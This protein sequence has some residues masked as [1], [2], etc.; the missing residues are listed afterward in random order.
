[1]APGKEDI[2]LQPVRFKSRGLYLIKYDLP[3]SVVPAPL[4][5]EENMS[6]RHMGEE[7]DVIGEWE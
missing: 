5:G 7:K 2:Q 6:R 4:I 1:V 3:P